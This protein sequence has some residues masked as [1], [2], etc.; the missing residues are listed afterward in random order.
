MYAGVRPF[1]AASNFE[2][3]IAFLASYNSFDGYELFMIEPSGNKY[4]YHAC[5]HGKG[6]A[7]CKSEFE[8]RNFKDLTCK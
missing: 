5:T 1:G 6:R 7:V 8:R 3:I 2:L 4:A